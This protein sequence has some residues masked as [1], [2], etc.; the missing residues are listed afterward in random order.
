MVIRLMSS[1]TNAIRHSGASEV[2]IRLEH[3][4]REARLEVQDS[5]QGFAPMLKEKDPHLLRASG[6]GIQSMRER[7]QMVGGN[8]TVESDSCGVTVLATIPLAS[9]PKDSCVATA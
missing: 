3:D 9:V 5:G 6:V 4:E 8:L 7:L 1:L 2:T